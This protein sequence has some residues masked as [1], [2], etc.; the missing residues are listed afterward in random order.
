MR[1]HPCKEV[2]GVRGKSELLEESLSFPGLQV[3]KVSDNSDQLIWIIRR[4]LMPLN[5]AS[6]AVHE[7]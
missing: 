6:K 7:S 5:L 1:A 3:I 4:C 2:N